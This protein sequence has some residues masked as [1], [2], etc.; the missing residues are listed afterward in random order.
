[1]SS[2]LSVNICQQYFDTSLFSSAAEEMGPK[3]ENEVPMP[4]SNVRLVVP[5]EIDQGEER[6]ERPIL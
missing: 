5:A 2:G 6:G 4:L 1:V 3:V